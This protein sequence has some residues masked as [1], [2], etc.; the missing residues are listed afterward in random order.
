MSRE[1][2]L[3][4]IESLYEA[5]GRGDVEAIL[6]HVADDVDWAADA[7]SDDAPWYGRRTSKDE[8]A[9]FFG[10]IAGAIQVLEFTP[11]ALAANDDAVFAFIRFSYRGLESGREATVNLHHYFRFRDGKIAYYRGSEDTALTADT[12][13]DSRSRVQTAASV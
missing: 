2:H 12:L 3:A 1:E 13:S 5:F 7:R 11:V 9:R 10:D 6:A 8:V 4:T